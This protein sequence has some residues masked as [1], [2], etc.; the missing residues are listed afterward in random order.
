[1]GQRLKKHWFWVQSPS[2]TS[3]ICFSL[4][5]AETSFCIGNLLLRY[6]PNTTY[7]N[8]VLIK[9][10]PSVHIQGPLTD[11]HVLGEKFKLS[12]DQK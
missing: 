9:K 12:H 11:T 8:N 10:C 5:K 2:G 7:D 4:E 3:T 1:M 6:Y